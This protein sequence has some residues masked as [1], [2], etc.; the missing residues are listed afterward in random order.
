MSSHG[1]LAEV[2][3]RKEYE[4]YRLRVVGHS[5]GAGCA[6]ML[7]V[8]L[9]PKYP[10]IRCLA[11]SPPGCVFSE[12]LADECS[13]WV[14]S[15]VLDDDIVSRLSIESFEDL[16]NDVL[17]MICRIKVPKYKTLFSYNP[18]NS[19]DLKAVSEAN[20]SLLYNKDEIKDSDFKRDLD[21]FF[22]F[23]T[24][25]KSKEKERYVRLC[26]PGN[27]VQLFRM[28]KNLSS[29]IDLSDERRR[30]R[31]GKEYA[32]RF[33]KRDYFR[34]VVISSHLLFDHDPI[35]VKN[36]LRELASKFGLEPPYANTLS[37]HPSE[38]T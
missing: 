9:R 24:D 4:G 10:T 20:L 18:K 17:E 13:T 29:G 36:R 21:S 12:N 7:S 38:S 5:L 32:A 37:S 15:Y 30:Q 19:D 27:T 26:V 1:R 16:R 6:A 14:T 33:V 22:Q 28:G 2:M 23:Q 3:A 8:L 11:F 25:L 31:K 34:K 35:N